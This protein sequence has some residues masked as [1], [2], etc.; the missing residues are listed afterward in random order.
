MRF[1]AFYVNNSD[2]RTQ[3]L[4]VIYDAINRKVDLGVE[5]LRTPQVETHPTWI[6]MK[7]LM[8]LPLHMQCEWF[9]YTEGELKTIR[10]LVIDIEATAVIIV[11]PA[12]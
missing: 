5:P 3:A 9:H 1:V 8:N 7:T 11:G 6:D 2:R 12:T 4:H 10:L